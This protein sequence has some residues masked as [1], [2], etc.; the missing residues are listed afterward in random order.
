MSLFSQTV[1]YL[2]A[3]ITGWLMQGKEE[4]E[5][6]DLLFAKF[7]SQMSDEDDDKLINLIL[8]RIEAWE[9]RN[10]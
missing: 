1:S 3:N 5:I 2:D 4:I 9:E 6:Y 8:D 10:G 7:G